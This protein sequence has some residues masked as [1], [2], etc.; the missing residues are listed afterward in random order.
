MMRRR[1]RAYHVVQVTHT[2][3]P[4]SA[5]VAGNDPFHSAEFLC[6]AD[7]A[8]LVVNQQRIYGTDEDVDSDEDGLEFVNVI[9]D[10]SDADLDTSITQGLCCGLVERAL[11][12]HSCH[13]LWKVSCARVEQYIGM[14]TYEV[15]GV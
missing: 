5:E 2:A 4:G 10:V 14:D 12:Y 9:G 15:A 6:S 3:S 7:D 11:P 13:S 1:E 8:F